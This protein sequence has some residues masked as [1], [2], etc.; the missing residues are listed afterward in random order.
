M[1]DCFCGCDEP[2]DHLLLL[3][4]KKSGY[5]SITKKA[6]KEAT[7]CLTSGDDHTTTAGK[8][9]DAQDIGIDEG[10]LELL[11]ADPDEEEQDTG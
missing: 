11:F 2:G 7:K 1:H 6:L 9:G 5:F 10:D 8:D 3:L 4:A